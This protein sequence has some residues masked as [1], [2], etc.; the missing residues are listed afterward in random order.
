MT[1]SF[2]VSV[3]TEL[4]DRTRCATRA[5]A[6][7]EVFSCTEG[8]C[9]PWRRHS[10]NGQLSPVESEGRHAQVARSVS[11]EPGGA[12]YNPSS[13]ASTAPKRLQ[14]LGDDTDALH[15][16]EACPGSTDHRIAGPP[17]RSVWSIVRPGPLGGIAGSAA[18][19]TP[20]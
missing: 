13:Q 15:S 3:E 5:E 8:F 1:E 9:N 10:A 14:P 6:E 18:H 19:L 16:A 7:R 11:G 20:V 17:S 4:I 2:S 12:A